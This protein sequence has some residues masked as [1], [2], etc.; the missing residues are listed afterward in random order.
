[1]PPRALCI[2]GMPGCGKEE[3]LQV[4]AEGGFAVV[5]M[6]DVVRAEAARRGIPATDAGVGG[7]AD[8]E[9]RLHG[10]AVWARRTLEA[11]Q[12]DEIVIDGVRSLHE[13]VHFQK[14]FGEGLTVVAIHASPR[15]RHRRIAERAREDDAL[16]EEDLRQRDERE[17][18]WGL[19][20]VIAM[21]D[22]MIVNEGNLEALQSQARA[23]LQE[24]FG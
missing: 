24:I 7:M 5:R 16:T 12:A 6:G 11:V 8:E 17:L 4:A 2:T 14:A 3:V 19:G 21:A 13:V 1:M 9:R 22:R 10:P 18:S 20:H 15:T 23:L